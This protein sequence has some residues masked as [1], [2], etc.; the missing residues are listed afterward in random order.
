MMGRWRKSVGNQGRKHHHRPTTP[1]QL[2][3][4]GGRAEPLKIRQRVA[5]GITTSPRSLER[6]PTASWPDMLAFLG[7]I[8]GARAAPHCRC[9]AASTTGRRPRRT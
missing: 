6:Q 7:D 1:T 9:R 3:L 8:R 4:A 5:H 2:V